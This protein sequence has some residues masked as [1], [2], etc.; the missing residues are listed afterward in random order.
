MKKLIY[1]CPICH[2]NV[3]YEDLSNPKAARSRDSL[4]TE[5]LYCSRCEM[6]VESII[7]SVEE[8]AASEV[9]PHDAASDYRGRTQQGG[10]NAGGSQRRGDLLVPPGYGRLQRR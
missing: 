9:V 3:R 7:T 4:A 2:G 1:S 8:D 10:S 5:K 6:I